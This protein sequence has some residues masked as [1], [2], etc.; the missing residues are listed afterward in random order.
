MW[1]N[2]YQ[3]YDNGSTWTPSR[4]VNR[5]VKA[6][7]L[8][9]VSC[10]GLIVISYALRF[11]EKRSVSHAIEFPTHVVQNNNTIDSNYPSDISM[12]IDDA[13]SSPHN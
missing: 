5:S 1:K 9:D 10:H 7:V 6:K 12:Y 8:N 11:L 2:I 4:A 3:V 13:I